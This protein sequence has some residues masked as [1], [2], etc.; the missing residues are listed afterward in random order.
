MSFVFK[1][2]LVGLI[3]NAVS[4]QNISVLEGDALEPLDEAVD[5]NEKL[6]ALRAEYE[7]KMQEIGDDPEEDAKYEPYPTKSQ[8]KR[9][10]AVKKWYRE[11]VAKVRSGLKEE[12]SLD[13]ADERESSAN[14]QAIERVQRAA[15]NRRDVAKTRYESELE[16]IRQD[17]RRDILSIKNLA[18][19]RESL[20]IPSSQEEPKKNIA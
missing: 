14:R 19:T 2:K 18:K 15:A 1:D 3:V 17:E 8:K 12:V 4:G 13:E 9:E 7:R 20:K 6:K 16:K 5:V 10:A 11:A